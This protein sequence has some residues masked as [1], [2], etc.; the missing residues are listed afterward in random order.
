MDL[1][2]EEIHSL[3]AWLI[4]YRPNNI[5]I[6]SPILAVDT[7]SRSMDFSIIIFLRT[8]MLLPFTFWPYWMTILM[9]GETARLFHLF[10]F[11]WW[12]PRR[13]R[14]LHS[15]I[16]EDVRFIYFD[17]R[18]LGSIVPCNGIVPLHDKFTPEA[19]AW[20]CIM[21]CWTFCEANIRLSG[22]LELLWM[23]I[24]ILS[25]PSNFRHN[26]SLLAGKVSSKN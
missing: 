20:I 9:S 23:G 15:A 11:C 25:M 6:T 21:I 3:I 2:I 22:A 4:V 18:K 14:F 17:D 13:D 24:P 26:T 12:Q 7:L 8:K 5:S 10:L 16:I 1:Q 19:V